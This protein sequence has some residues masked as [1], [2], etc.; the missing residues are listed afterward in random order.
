MLVK[1]QLLILLEKRTRLLLRIN[2]VY[3]P[4]VQ[5]CFPSTCGVRIFASLEVA[6][7]YSYYTTFHFSSFAVLFFFKKFR[8]A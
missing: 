7:S 6:G 5:V 1:P 8:N 4:S 3:F 2:Y